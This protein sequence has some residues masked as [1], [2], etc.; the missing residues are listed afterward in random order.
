MNSLLL[1]TKFIFIFLFCCLI[2]AGGNAQ[3]IIRSSLS[4]LGNSVTETD[5]RYRS[6]VG[7]PSNTFLFSEEKTTL[8]QGFQQPF[9]SVKSKCLSCV[10]CEF[11]FYP[12]P[13]NY[14]T[15]VYLNTP[16]KFE[17]IIIKDTQGR[18]CKI[19]S[20]NFF[21]EKTIDISALSNGIYFISLKN[22]DT[23]SCSKKLVVLK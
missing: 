4:C 16:D 17:S 11:A 18:I 6:T 22:S 20:G 2:F 3:Q 23:Y 19:Y 15:L 21:S 14:N 5:F 9:G 13:T 8:R 1:N 12:N 10:F 7:Q